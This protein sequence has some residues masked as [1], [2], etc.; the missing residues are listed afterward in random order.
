MENQNNTME[1]NWKKQQAFERFFGEV[2]SGPFKGGYSDLRYVSETQQ[3]Y[4]F[5][6]VWYR[7]TYTPDAMKGRANYV[8]P[9]SVEIISK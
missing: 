7:F 6:N 4:L 5:G 9:V 2:V 3:D 1:N 8:N